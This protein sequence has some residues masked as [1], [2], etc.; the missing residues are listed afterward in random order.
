MATSA[1][2]ARS[3]G[4]NLYDQLCLEVGWGDV[5]RGLRQVFVAY[6]VFIVGVALGVG[7][8]MVAVI[9]MGGTARGGPGHVRPALLW[10]FYLGLGILSV[11]GVLTW[12]MVMAGKW[13]CVQNAPERHAARWV[14]F[15]CI[16][17]TFIGPVF[18]SAAGIGMTQKPVALKHG[19]RGLQELKLTGTGRVVHLIGM[20]CALLTPLFFLLFLRAVALCMGAHT[21][22]VI[23]NG[24]IALSAGLA[25]VTGYLLLLPP[26]L[27]K[28]LPVLGLLGVGWAVW[29]V[30][31]LVLILLIR[32]VI[33]R[34]VE[35]L[36]SPL[37]LSSGRWGNADADL[38]VQPV[39][40]RS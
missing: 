26:P 20:G 34:T 1:P 15:V 11:I 16:T 3:D 39:S 6:V 40:F 23:M 18:N 31:Y 21:H 25:G 19:P 27:E 24:Y 17:C 5:A 35:S 28:A 37:E 12:V 33:L 10:Q 7:L 30:A 13:R 29:G 4:L 22:M 9:K 36:R 2:L 14:M 8:V 38:A 32:S